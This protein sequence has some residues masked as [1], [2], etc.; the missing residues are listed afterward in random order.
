VPSHKS[1]DTFRENRS[2]NTTQIRDTLGEVLYKSWA[3]VSEEMFVQ[4]LSSIPLR[5]QAVTEADR[6][7]RCWIQSNFAKKCPKTYDPEL[8]LCWSRGASCHLVG[9]S[10]G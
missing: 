7:V 4:S 6:C 3:N 10:I 5:N 2:S 9:Y 1:S 8:Y